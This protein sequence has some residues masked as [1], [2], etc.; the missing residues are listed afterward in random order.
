METKN[1]V[2]TI[3]GAKCCDLVATCYA[4]VEFFQE[5]YQQ[6]MLPIEINLIISRL[7]QDAIKLQE[8]LTKGENALSPAILKSLLSYIVEHSRFLY[9]WFHSSTEQ[10]V[11]I[12]NKI[13]KI[14][15][16]IATTVSNNISIEDNI[17]HYSPIHGIPDEHLYQDSY[18]SVSYISKKYN[19]AATIPALLYMNKDKNWKSNPVYSG[20]LSHHDVDIS[21]YS[22][23]NHFAKPS[24]SLIATIDTND[25]STTSKIKLM[26]SVSDT[27]S[28]IRSNPDLSNNKSLKASSSHSHTKLN[29]FRNLNKK[30]SNAKKL[31]NFSIDTILRGSNKCMELHYSIEDDC[32]TCFNKIVNNDDRDSIV[33]TNAVQQQSGIC[34][35]KCSENDLPPNSNKQDEIQVNPSIPNLSPRKSDT[36]NVDK[37]KNTTHP[38]H[39]DQCKSKKSMTITQ[40]ETNLLYYQCQRCN[41]VFQRA[42]SL[43]RHQRIHTGEKPYNC[44]ICQKSFTQS[45]HLKIH[46]R[47]HNGDLRYACDICGKKFIQNNDLKKHRRTHTGEK[48]YCCTTCKKCFTDSSQLRKH[49]RVHSGHKPYSCEICGKSFS[50]SG[51]LMKHKNVHKKKLQS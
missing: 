45:F 43:K 44:N 4:L 28:F 16:S 11:D 21:N 51:T 47:I 39:N 35:I 14:S 6:D 22:I 40:E 26:P 24:I 15:S 32:D 36:S 41:K 46:K 37:N 5:H 23:S 7:L 48:P 12:I 27:L 38:D 29:K 34:Q 10:I 13:Q 30:L 31:T 33:N 17:K 18:P 2:S 19:N 8:L 20:P 42:Y 9:Q 3:D 50:Q 1:F 49:E 25:P